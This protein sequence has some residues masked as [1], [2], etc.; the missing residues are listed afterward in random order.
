MPYTKKEIG[1]QKTLT[2]LFAAKKTEEKA[3]KMI[4][5]LSLWFSE[6]GASG[7][8]A[9]E[10]V[11]KYDNAFGRGLDFYQRMQ[12]GVSVKAR[13]ADLKRRGDLC[14]N[15]DIRNNCEVLQY[16]GEV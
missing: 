4:D 9:R 5:I 3:P 11:I 10:M 12:A 8:S 15:G 1:Y 6:A 2:S 7:A 16:I 13:V 14:W